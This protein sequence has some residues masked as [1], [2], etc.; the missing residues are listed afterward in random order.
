MKESLRKAEIALHYGLLGTGVAAAGYGAKYAYDTGGYRH[1][2]TYIAYQND[3]LLG[4]V[5]NDNIQ[6]VKN[7]V[8]KGADLIAIGDK[9]LRMARSY[10]LPD[11]EQYL[12]EE[13]L[14]QQAKQLAKEKAQ[15]AKEKAIQQAI[16]QSTEK[17][18]QEA[19][20]RATQRAKQAKEQAD[21]V[22]SLRAIQEAYQA[23]Q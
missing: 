5:G 8:A 13:I 12:N 6:G 14:K 15:L 19:E 4:A 16:Q 23:R 11:I 21:H 7:A 20:Q 18:V 17:A 9:A 22:A 1:I 2:P 3:V 10:H